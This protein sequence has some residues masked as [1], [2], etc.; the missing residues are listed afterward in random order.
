M[1]GDQRKRGRAAAAGAAERARTAPE[2]TGTLHIPLT[3]YF[4]P[5]PVTSAIRI[6]GKEFQHFLTTLVLFL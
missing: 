5:W 3:V 2:S 6:K 1:T 4:N